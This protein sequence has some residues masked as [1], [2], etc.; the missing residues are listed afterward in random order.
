MSYVS[1]KNKYVL[2]IVMTITHI[3]NGHSLFLHNIAMINN[4]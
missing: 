2:Y 3:D 4:P 1:Y